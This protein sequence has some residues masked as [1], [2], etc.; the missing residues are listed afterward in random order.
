MSKV[1]RACFLTIICSSVF[2]N[3]FTR[4][5]FGSKDSAFKFANNTGLIVTSNL[6]IDEGTLKKEAQATFA[7]APIVFNEGVLQLG[8]S[9]IALTGTCD[10]DEDYSI[11]LTGNNDVFCAEPGSIT[12]KISVSGSQNRIEGQPVFASAEAIK[13]QDLNTT[14]TLAIH[15]A[16]NSN[17]VLNE[18]TLCLDHNLKLGDD[19]CFT[20]TGIIKCFGFSV[21]MGGTACSWPDETVM[22][23]ENP[24]INLTGDVDLNGEWRFYGT[25]SIV[26]NGNVLDITDGKICVQPDASLFLTNIRINGVTNNSL[27]FGNQGSRL[28]LRGADLKLSNDCTYTTGGIYVEGTS[29]IITKNNFLT[30]DLGSS[31]TVDGAVLW[32][33]TLA[34]GDRNNIQP[35]QNDDPNQLR[36]T[37]LRDGIIKMNRTT[38]VGVKILSNSE[39]GRSWNGD[40]QINR[41]LTLTNRQ[42]PL[43]QGAEEIRPGK[44]YRAKADVIFDG[45]LQTLSF[46]K[47]TAGDY[48]LIEVDPGQTLLFENVTLEGFSFDRIELGTNAQIVFGDNTRVVITDPLINLSSTMRFQGNASLEGTR[49][50]V[51]RL[52]TA[53]GGILID[54]NSSLLL[55]NLSIKDLSGNQIRCFDNTGTISFGGKVNLYL[56]DTYSLTV[57]HFEIMPASLLDIRGSYSFDYNSDRESIIYDTGV[58]QLSD[59]ATFYYSPIIDD[60]E[61]IIFDGNDAT[62]QLNNGTLAS[63]TTGMHLTVGKVRVVG[64]KNYFAGADAESLS[65]AIMVG[66]GASAENNVDFKFEKNGKLYVWVDPGLFVWANYGTIDDRGTLIPGE[67]IIKDLTPVRAAKKKGVVLNSK[68]VVFKVVTKPR[69]GTHMS[70][71]DGSF[72]GQNLVFYG[73]GAGISDTNGNYALFN[74]E[75]NPETE[76]IIPNEG[77]WV[78]L[79]GGLGYSIDAPA[80]CEI[81]GE[82]LVSA[83]PVGGVCPTG[84]TLT[85]PSGIVYLSLDTS[86]VNI[87]LNGGKVVFNRTLRFNDKARFVSSGTVDLNGRSLILGGTDLTWDNDIWWQNANDIQLNSR[88]TLESAWYFDGDAHISGNGN[89]LDISN[90]GTLW[91]RPNTTLSLTN[92]KLKGLGWGTIMFDDT[93]S[94]LRLSNVEI[95]MDDNYTF[96]TGGIYVDGPTNIVTKN[97]IFTLDESSSMTLD[98]ISLTYDTLEFVNQD[99]IQP[100]REVDPHSTHITYLNNAVVR[101]YNFGDV[102]SEAYYDDDV[103]LTSDFITY[104]TKRIFF[105]NSLILNG[106][107]HV[108]SFSRTDEALIVV[109]DG[110]EAQFTNVVLRDFSPVHVSLGTDSSLIFNDKTVI[111]L[112]SSEDLTYTWTF[113]GECILN[114]KG[115]TIDLSSGGAI[116]VAEAGSS[117]LLDNIIIKGLSNNNLRCMDSHCTISLRNAT[118][119]LTDDYNFDVGHIEILSDVIIKGPYS[120]NYMTDQQSSI[121]TDGCLFLDYGTTLN[122]EPSNES[123]DLLRFAD[124]SARLYLKGATLVSSTTG[125]CLTKGT[126]IVDH[127]VTVAAEGTSIPE[128]I[129]FGNRNEDD[130]L[131]IHYMPGASIEVSSGYLDYANVN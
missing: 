26:G 61:L 116:E 42:H 88:V 85:D 5:N 81:L 34:N 17:I 122:Y 89:V 62:L 23:K 74:G 68:P 48:P 110:R 19:V 83:L 96:T 18:G 94:E 95:E 7:G 80:G 125:L 2:F 76:H 43:S 75:F 128:A 4:V 52:T 49:D 8:K 45:D 121:L 54:A 30:F 113:K 32:Y 101:N 39:G 66:D 98:G 90:G 119:S 123:R 58:L 29:T 65:E 70:L 114:G 14:V 12:D 9:D 59:G 22:W 106:N 21:S 92:L 118:I 129:S 126:L 93:S 11:I 37:F 31:L 91:I 1:I 6:A 97:Y 73:D 107:T 24:V 64:E 3:G 124:Q 111:E 120:L 40:G 51:I 56:D 72:T 63:T 78:L 50:S 36:L 131:T 77:T 27:E 127:N 57:G 82:L 112:A 28:Y 87:D 69:A 115:Q 33:D 100:N 53:Y 130:D 117:L 47:S 15:N 103:D 104:P 35:E 13:L 102:L 20:N 16:L 55:Q 41:Y 67:M 46:V 86:E 60:R 109:A 84:L 108:I 25:G 10:F 38:A 44:G 79:H 105:D 99:N 71:D